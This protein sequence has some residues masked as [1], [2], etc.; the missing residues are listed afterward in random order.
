M[1]RDTVLN[2]LRD[3]WYQSD[4]KS[5]R[6]LMLMGHFFLN[7]DDRSRINRAIIELERSP[8]APVDP[9]VVKA[10]DILGGKIIK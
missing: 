3:A 4:V 7:D 10:I 8:K 1:N 2:R 5:M 6:R 9:L